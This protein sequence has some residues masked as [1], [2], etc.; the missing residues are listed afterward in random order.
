MSTTASNYNVSSLLWGTALALLS[1]V[2]AFLALDP[3]R[4]VST[5]GIFYT[6]A[7]LMYCVSMFASSY[8]EEEH[9]F[10]YM[11]TATWFMYLFLSR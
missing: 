9:N 7:L 3:I 6:G 8:V 5:N 10:W 1:S 4:A 2:L 11:M